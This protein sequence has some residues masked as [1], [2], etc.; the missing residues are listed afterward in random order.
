MAEEPT[1]T[2][3]AEPDDESGLQTDVALIVAA[4]G[5]GPGD[6]RDSGVRRG[7]PQPSTEAGPADHPRQ[8]R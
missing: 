4:L 8:S 5:G 7:T 1:P 6:R 2:E 3:A